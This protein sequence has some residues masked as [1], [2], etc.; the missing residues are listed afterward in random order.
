ML[1][2]ECD[3]IL[4]GLAVHHNLATTCTAIHTRKHLKHAVLR[5]KKTQAKQRYI[6][7]NMHS[8]LI[9]LIKPPFSWL[10]A[11]CL[12]KKYIASNKPNG[13]ETA[14]QFSVLLNHS[15]PKLLSRFVK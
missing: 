14:S 9:T 11:F 3:E 15:T 1:M 2:S 13:K 6:S 4:Y 8:K 12:S 7:Y 5:L 10:R